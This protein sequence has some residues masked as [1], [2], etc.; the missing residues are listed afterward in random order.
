MMTESIAL[1]RRS[2]VLATVIG[3]V[4]ASYAG[5]AAALEWEFD[6]GGRLNWNTTLSV[7]A[8]WRADDPSRRLYT[9]AD[10]SLIGKYTAPL[11]PGTPVGPKDGLAGN[12]SAGIANLNYAK[13]DRFTTPFKLITDLEYKKDNWGGLVRVKAWYDQ[14]LNDKTV[15]IGS[16]AN[17]FNGV[18]PG[19]GPL[20]GYGPC[21][22]ATPEGISCL[23]MSPPGQNL[24][25]RARLRDDGF[26]DEQK[27]ENVYLLDAYVYGTF[28][29]GNSDLQVRLGNQVINWGES[30]FIQ[31]VNQ[32]NPIDVP[33]ARRAGAELKEILLPVWAAYINWG[34]D[35]GS[36]EAFYQLKWNNTSVD[37]CG[38]YFTQT[39]TLI[40]SDPGSCD[41]ITVVG[42]QLGNLAPGVPNNIVA[43][44]GSQPFLQAN[45]TYVPAVKG[46][47]ASDSGQFGVA[48]RFPVS[49]IDTEIGL[50]AMN[51][52]NR[53]PISSGRSGTN[54]N[55][56]PEPYRTA[57]ASQGLIGNDA[58]GPYWKLPTSTTLY[59]SLMPIL[60]SAYEGILGGAVDLTSGVGFWEYPEDIQIY[61]ISAATNILSWSVS[62]ELSYQADVPAQVN[63]NDLIAGSIFGI[64]P[65]REETSRVAKGSEGG[66]LKGYGRFDKTQFQVNTVKTFS[67]ILGAGNVL[68]IGEV[69]FQWN[70]VP[71]Y[72][73]GGVRYGRGFMFGTGSGPEYGPGG[74]PS[75]QPALGGAS[76]GNLCSP[77]FTGVPVPV[78]NTL[79]NPSPDGCRNDGYIT[80]MAWGYRLRVSADYINV[81][82][83]GVTVTPS[84]FWSHDVDGVSIDP[85]FIEDRQV[86]G[87]GVKFNYNKKYTMDFNYVSYANNNFDPLFDRDYYSASIGM[88]F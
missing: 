68:L 82:N 24:W 6:N 88:T 40:S 32:I 49:A 11:V 25:P 21:T 73:K 1:G 53:L 85:Q 9:R 63:G 34:F 44:F 45:G 33:A 37:G 74:A 83:S 15:R 66:Y 4:L 76:L 55:D 57:L 62:A 7:G 60:E 22:P 10:G 56:I 13:G 59:R 28:G 48:F 70:N 77:T 58:Y 8:S 54:P 31:G 51:I 86:L 17:D 67:N 65:Y 19:L 43:Q 46:R 30:V 75:G 26:E 71:D 79:Y 14:A 84:V 12:Q 42:G 38:T 80:D 61:G 72:T 81:F 52:H 20:P 36:L 78:F 27:F 3:T 2:T 16:Q 50:Y 47:D 5:G 41:S 35:F 39:A 18:R 29:V 87:L 69:G 64:G 23:P